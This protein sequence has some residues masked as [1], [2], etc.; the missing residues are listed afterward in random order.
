[1]A[2]NNVLGQQRKPRTASGRVPG[3]ELRTFFRAGRPFGQVREP[4]VI[5]H[6]QL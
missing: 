1:M 3:R 2:V 4:A 6:R 5:P